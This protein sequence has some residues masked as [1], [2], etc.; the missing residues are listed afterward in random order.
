MK[1]LAHFGTRVATIF[2]E[3]DEEGNNL[4]EIPVE[5][6]LRALSASAFLELFQRLH[7]ERNAKREQMGLPPLAM[8]AATVNLL[9][10]ARKL[11]G[12]AQEAALLQKVEQSRAGRE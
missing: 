10:Y 5:I 11:Q 4:R 1:Q 2:A 3:V 8:D 7:E 12:E 6:G 9:E